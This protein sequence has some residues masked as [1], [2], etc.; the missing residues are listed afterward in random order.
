MPAPLPGILSLP[1][2]GLDLPTLFHGNAYPSGT[3]QGAG[4]MIHVE[5]IFVY[6]VRKRSNFMFFY[7][8]LQLSQHHLLKR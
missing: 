4:W 7:V 3:H 1:T 2:G 8:D 6:G 5:L